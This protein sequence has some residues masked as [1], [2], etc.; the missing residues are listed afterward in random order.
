MQEII[1]NI[2]SG[3]NSI[4]S[5]KYALIEFSK[6]KLKNSSDFFGFFNKLKDNKIYRLYNKIYFIYNGGNFL[7]LTIKFNKI[8]NNQE[9]ILIKSMI[10]TIKEITLLHDKIRFDELTKVGNLKKLKE[11]ILFYIERGKRNKNKFSLVFLDLDG[12]KEINDFLGHLAGNFILKNFASFINKN[13]RYIDKLYRYGGDEFVLILEE[14][15]KKEAIFLMEKI[16]KE[17]SKKV[18]LI[19]EN[20]L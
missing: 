20:K 3:L 13:T 18:F 16:I 12:F 1:K 7:N 5:V 8:P 2:S 10:S 19:E 15:S 17:L 14:T 4:S 6:V 11:D 9:K